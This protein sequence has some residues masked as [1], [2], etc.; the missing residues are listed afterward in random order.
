MEIRLLKSKRDATSRRYQR[1]GSR[2]LLNK[3]LE[4]AKTVEEQ[5]ET[6][7]C[8]HLHD[9][10]KD[11]L[12]SNKNFCREMRTLGLLPKSNGALHGF[13]PE[14]LNAHYT[15]ISL[16]TSEDSKKS[17]RFIN[18]A[19]PDG[20]KFKQVTVNDII[21]AVKH[22]KSQATGEDGIP[23]SVIAKAL[24]ILAPYLAKLFNTSLQNGAYPQSWKKS[25]ILALRKIPSPSSP[26]DFHPISLLCF[27]SKVLEKLAYDQVLDFLNATKIPDRLQLAS[28]NFT[29]L[30][31]L[32]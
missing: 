17:L 8:A 19:S 18:N 15:G 21:L 29:A 11:S 31:R 5:T 4:L 6:A 20:F 1:T 24:P 12:D 13:L 2:Q 14:E 16:P 3:F 7:R 9:R 25:R 32:C 10:I 23:Q 28:K 22:F 30:N 27:L 26:S